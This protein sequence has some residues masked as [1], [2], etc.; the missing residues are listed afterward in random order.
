MS[1]RGQIRG[2]LLRRM[3]LVAAA[4]GILALLFLISGHWILG[5]VFAVGAAV[6]LW[7]FLQLRTVR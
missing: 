2:R 3:G 7:L 5:I 1:A 4:V 6:A